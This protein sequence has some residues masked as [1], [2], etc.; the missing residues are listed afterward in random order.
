MATAGTR[1]LRARLEGVLREREDQR[2]AEGDLVDVAHLRE[3]RRKFEE[4]RKRKPVQQEVE[5]EVAPL[6]VLRGKFEEAARKNENLRSQP[7]PEPEPA[8][9]DVE[10]KEQKKPPSFASSLDGSMEDFD[11]EEIEEESD[12]SPKVRKIIKVFCLDFSIKC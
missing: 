6:S 12:Q 7:K 1:E 4:A 11:V 3:L 5:V 2:K 10:A 9:Q 8:Q